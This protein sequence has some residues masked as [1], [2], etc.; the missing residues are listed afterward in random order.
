MKYCLVCLSLFCTIKLFAQQHIWKRFAQAN[1][2]PHTTITAFAQTADGILWIGSQEGLIRYNGIT[3]EHTSKNTPVKP[4]VEGILTDRQQNLFLATRSGLWKYNTATDQLFKLRHSGV[5]ISLHNIVWN[6]DSTQIIAASDNGIFAYKPDDTFLLT[7]N[8]S[9]RSSHIGRVFMLNRQL[10]ATIGKR[11]IW[12]DTHLKKT[13]QAIFK[14]DVHD[15]VWYTLLQKYV[16]LTVDGLAAYNTN[17]DTFEAVGPKISMAGLPYSQ[18]LF[19]DHK[20]RLWINTIDTVFRLN[21]LNKYTIPDKCFWEK[22]NPA[23]IWPTSI[24]FFEDSKHN[25]WIGSGGSGLTV[26]YQHLDAIRYLHPFSYGTSHIW[27]VYHDTLEGVILYGTNNS[28]VISNDKQSPYNCKIINRPK[29]KERFTV[30]CFTSFNKHYWLVGT[31]GGGLWLLHKRTH[32]LRPFMH[33]S[34]GSC[35]TF[36]HLPDGSLL[37]LGVGFI[38]RYTTGG[39]MEYTWGDILSSNNISIAAAGSNRY[40]IGSSNG[41]LQVTANGHVLKKFVP[42]EVNPDAKSDF[43]VMALYYHHTTGDLYAATMNWGLCVIKK[44]SNKIETIPLLQLPAMVYGIMPYQQND[45]LLTTGNGLYKYN[46]KT[47]KSAVA[48]MLNGLPF[49]EFDQFGYYYSQHQYTGIGSG[50]YITFPEE[51]VDQLFYDTPAFYLFYNNRYATQVNLSDSVRSLNMTLTPG[52][53][54]AAQSVKYTYQINELDHSFHSS[55]G[56]IQYNYLPPGIYTLTIKAED[57]NNR[58]EPAVITM[59]IYVQP[60][61]YE[62]FGF[63]LLSG[64][65]GIVFLIYLVRYFSYLRLQWNLRKLEAQQKVAEER[66]RISREL[67]DNVGSQLTYLIMGLEASEM[68]L[69]QQHTEKL[70]ANIEQLQLS[71]RD[72]MQQLRDA[73]WALNKEE[74]TLQLLAERFKNWS[75]KMTENKIIDVHFNQDIQQAHHLDAIATLNIFRLLQEAVHNTIKHAQATQLDVRI[76]TTPHLCIFIISDNGIGLSGKKEGY[77][78]ENMKSRAN[79]IGAL[80]TMESKKNTGTTIRIEYPIK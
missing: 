18:C 43:P 9:S 51:A 75:V 45:L 36:F 4:Y 17:K 69:E 12:F 80:F 42:K 63:K 72:S 3:F 16:V 34:T 68:L 24:G 6:A 62:S 77:G 22:D 44:G 60:R 73:I 27:S 5:D 14:N 79:Q 35:N 28:I 37:M 23:S 52:I 13:H 19:I 21:S 74:M 54:A 47:G 26:N 61:W 53:D 46:V 8:W 25:I 48:N 11:I 49:N 30:T 50:G 29:A 76:K 65:C 70:S 71:A 32:L 38:Y 55:K 7:E 2:L 1:G 15:I 58:F 10:F 40:F 31:Y 57:I 67:H 66:L 39:T 78:I 59:S 20:N 64:I 33:N 56:D 41:I